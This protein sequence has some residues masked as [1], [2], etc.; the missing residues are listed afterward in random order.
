[1]SV[2][3]RDPGPGRRAP[4]GWRAGPGPTGPTADN[5]SATIYVALLVLGTAALLQGTIIARIHLLGVV[6]NLM[7]VIVVAWSLLHGVTAGLVWAF[8]GGLALDLIS[9]MPMGT[10]S[11]ALMTACLV[12]GIGTNKVFSTNL[13]FPILVVSLATAL[14]GWLVL[15]VMQLR[16]IPVDWIASTVHIIGP[17][18][19]LNVCL[20]AVAYPILLRYSRGTLRQSSMAHW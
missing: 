14:N 1:M 6:P 5:R 11:L 7:L 3:S 10:S 20:M 12:A 19:L 4:G 17:E 15:L 16:G 8:A 2:A 13:L 9:G 18:L